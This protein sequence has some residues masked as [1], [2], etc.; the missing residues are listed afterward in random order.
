MLA[1]KTYEGCFLIRLS[2]KLKPGLI[3]LQELL[4]PVQ[5]KMAKKKARS[6]QVWLKIA[7]KKAQSGPILSK[8]SLVSLSLV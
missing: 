3:R 7:M 5:L 6:G 4:G 2:R 1:K 8:P